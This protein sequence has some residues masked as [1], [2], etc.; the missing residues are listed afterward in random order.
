MWSGKV[1]WK[2]GLGC[3]I[4][5]IL[6]W[7]FGLF[8]SPF[9]R[10]CFGQLISAKYCS[11]AYHIVA[12]LPEVKFEE[13]QSSLECANVPCGARSIKMWM[14]SSRFLMKSLKHVSTEMSL[15]VLA[16]NLKRVMNILGNQ[17]FIAALSS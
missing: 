15:H 9:L 16:Y 6:G 10:L 17:K 14:G 13:V 7:S 8:S 12:I 2:N 4:C 1:S 5:S 11:F 3:Q